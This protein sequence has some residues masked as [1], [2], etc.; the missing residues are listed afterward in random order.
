MDVMGCSVATQASSCTPLVTANPEAAMLSD[1]SRQTTPMK[2]CTGK[3][4]QQAATLS[5][6]K[7]GRSQLTPRRPATLSAQTIS[8]LQ[9]ARLNVA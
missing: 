8:A 5:H 2:R 6:A 4:A 3:A 7:P 9:Q 1:F